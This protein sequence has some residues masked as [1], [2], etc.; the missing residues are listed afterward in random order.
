MSNA[1]GGYM[2][3]E[4]GQVVQGPTLE[5]AEKQVSTSVHAITAAYAAYLDGT[6]LDSKHSP[7]VA[8]HRAQ[9]LSNL[10]GEFAQA[11]YT[12]QRAAYLKAT[13]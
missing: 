2:N 11:A 12:L 8:A 10:T 1:L 9:V 6:R 5:E 3:R 13:K 4:V 7:E